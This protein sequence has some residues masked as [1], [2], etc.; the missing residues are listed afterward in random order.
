M[1][2]IKKLVLFLWKWLNEV[3]EVEG[4]IEQELEKYLFNRLPF[5][6]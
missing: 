6:F 3:K 1:L 2:F 4:E 5:P